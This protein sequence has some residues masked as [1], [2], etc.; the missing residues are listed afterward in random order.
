L[1]T[2]C[3]RAARR[4]WSEKAAPRRRRAREPFLEHLPGVDFDRNGVS[5]PAAFGEDTLESAAGVLVAVE[6]QEFRYAQSSPEPKSTTM[7]A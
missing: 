6:A 2:A 3:A 7:A 1:K 5:D 4:S